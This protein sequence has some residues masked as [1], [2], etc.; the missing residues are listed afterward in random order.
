MITRVCLSSNETPLQI[1]RPMKASQLDLSD[2]RMTPQWT[3]ALTVIRQ[4]SGERARVDKDIKTF[5]SLTRKEARSKKLDIAAP[6]D[7]DIWDSF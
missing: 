1:V 5:V 3:C 7:A 4:L 6:N 2:S